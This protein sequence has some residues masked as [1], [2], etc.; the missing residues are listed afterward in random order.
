[1]KVELLYAVLT[2]A[3]GIFSLGLLGLLLR[4]NLLLSFLAIE[5]LLNA[6]NLN[7]IAF[8]RYHNDPTGA[9]FVLFGICLAAVEAVIGLALT[10][11]IFRLHEDLGLAKL[12]Q[13]RW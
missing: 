13:L 2:L 6:A 10:V 12:A 7:F 11:R 8:S 9:M 3:G 1:M 5:L 4:R